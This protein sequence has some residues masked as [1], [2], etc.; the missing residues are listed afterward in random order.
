MGEYGGKQRKQESRAI[1]N[2]EVRGRQ[3]KRFADN[4]DSK[5]TQTTLQLYNK[6]VEPRFP[7]IIQDEFNRIRRV[8]GRQPGNLAYK[9]GDT[10]VY[11]GFSNANGHSEEQILDSLHGKSIAGNGKT[12]E[13]KAE[14]LRGITPVKKDIYTVKIPC[15]LGGKEYA[16]FNC[17]R[18]LSL[19]LT[20]DS[21]VSYT[22]AH[23]R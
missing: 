5:N 8:E 22:Y 20:T 19:G 16:N 3:F 1:A 2:S 12:V 6:K 11:E 10:T 23:E 17:D 14:L 7:Q 13:Q 18:L 4:R 21:T 15:P 9:I